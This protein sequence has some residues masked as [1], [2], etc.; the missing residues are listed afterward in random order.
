V[1]LSV[2]RRLV[3]KRWVEQFEKRGVGSSEFGIRVLGEFPSESDDGVVNGDD[4]KTAHAQNFEPGLPLVVGVDVARFGSDH[5]VLAVREGNRIRVVR[6]YQGRDLMQTS[7]AVT[8]L[9]RHL[10]EV[11]GRKPVIVIDDVGLGGGVTDRLRELGE[12]SIRDFNGGRKA[13][14]PCRR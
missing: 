2:R 7:G 1:P 12:F 9:A 4:L 10:Y 13:L 11:S 6:S 8:E 3:S 14:T 5:T